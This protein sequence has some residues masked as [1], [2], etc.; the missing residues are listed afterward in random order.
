MI[1]NQASFRKWSIGWHRLPGKLVM[2]CLFSG[3]L[4]TGSLLT[5]GLDVV[6]ICGATAFAAPAV[7]STDP[8]DQPPATVSA[9][10]TD[11]QDKSSGREAAPAA[12][13][14]ESSTKDDRSDTKPA[15]TSGTE[16]E[17]NQSL[18]AA[19][20][21]DLKKD[22]PISHEESKQNRAS[23][24]ELSRAF[25]D[26]AALCMP[27]VVT[28]KV[29][30]RDNES[31]GVIDIVGG[32]DDSFDGFG[33]GVIIQS[34][35]LILTNHHVVKDAKHI[36]IM[37]VDGRHYVARDV[38]SD[39]ASDLAITRIEVPEKLPFAEIGDSSE[40][41]VGDWVLAIGSPFKL[42][43]SVSA[44]II[45]GK[46]RP[47]EGF[48][49]ERFLQTDAAVNPGNSGGPLIDLDGKV[50]GINMAISSSSGAFQG[51][52]FA[53]PINRAMHVKSELVEHGRVRRA[54]IGAQLGSI[55]PDVANL[56][57]LPSRNGAYVVSV[58]SG[59]PA[60]K[61]GLMAGD[62]VTDFDGQRIHDGAELAE[63]IAVSPLERELEIG[64]MR[65]GEKKTLKIH[66][67]PR[68]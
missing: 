48:K 20:E 17:S 40:L 21:K 41:N 38:R 67:E 18:K 46:N 31:S 29:R 39:P 59:R 44:G 30:L 6:G 5:G 57:D 62:I 34:D 22:G 58:V 56:L 37:L 27:S 36:E 61:A 24:R 55:P 33:S 63:L 8:N 51:V 4:L 42:H 9:T 43:S 64:I 16:R 28:L 11:K 1:R 32:N 26:A 49:P 47:L 54:R 7:T 2:G 25:R 10:E 3:S 52:G 23:A 35:G 15:T 68:D 12:T 60:E 50:V 14:Q 66:L 65:G 19:A 13:P 53:I 45:S